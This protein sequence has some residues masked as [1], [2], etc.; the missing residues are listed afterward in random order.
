M[1]F[2]QAGLENVGNTKLFIT[3]TDPGYLAKKSTTIQLYNIIVQ[4]TI[5]RYIH[6]KTL[7][8]NNILKY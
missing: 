7:V 5:S 4:I 6:L 1:L 8:N 3:V 2:W